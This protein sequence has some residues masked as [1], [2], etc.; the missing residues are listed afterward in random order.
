MED[1][2]AL[3]WKKCLS[4]IGNNV[5]ER[6]FKTWFE[7]IQIVSFEEG[8]LTFG[9]PSQYFYE[10]ISEHFGRL[11]ISSVRRIFGDGTQL[12]YSLL[13]DKCH[14]LTID[15]EPATVSKPNVKEKSSSGGD[16]KAPNILQATQPQD[17]DPQLNWNY[18]FEN[19]VEG[20]GNRLPRSVGQSI[21]E[22]PLQSTFNPLFIYGSSGVGKTH[23]VNAIGAKIKELRPRE[24]VLYVSAHLF[25]VQYTDSVRRNTVND[26]I[27][28]YQSIDV[29]IIDD[30]QEFATLSK[31]QNTFFHIFNHLHQNG[32]K[33]VLTSDRPPTALQGMEERLLTRFKWGLLAEI[34]KPDL[35][36][37]RDILLSKIKQD[38]LDI[39]SD[40]VDYIAQNVTES[41]RELEGVLNSL[42]AYSVVWNRN[43]DLELAAQILHKTTPARKQNISLDDILENVCKY[44]NVTREDLL[45]TSRKQPVT[46]VRQ[47][48]MYLAQRHTDIPASRIGKLIGKRTHATVIHSCHVVTDLIGVDKTYKS[49]IDELETIL[50]NKL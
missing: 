36:L 17:L 24:R 37:R 19:F 21:A 16:N 50:R 33:L 9:L 4:I 34:E 11:I 1:S 32:R 20:V 8:T 14:S 25:Q 27:N 41:I 47:I 12:K 42:M 49:K 44:F 18:R 39:S 29:L 6:Q 40:V 46:T 15:I 7:P 3:L 5:D 31:T 35:R 30:V 22:H 10:F 2:K 43:I 13:V 26:F 23:L 38:G 28:F 48:A 45:S